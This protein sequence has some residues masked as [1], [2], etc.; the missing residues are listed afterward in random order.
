MPRFKLKGMLERDALADLWKHTLSQIPNTYGRLAYLASL[1]DPNSGSY[2]HYG[3]SAAFGREDSLGALRKSHEDTFLEWLRL[4]LSAKAEDL[5]EHFQ[6]LEEN[7]R[8]VV[9]YLARGMSY[10]GQAPD[11]A[12]RAQR[13][14]FQHEMEILLELLRNDSAVDRSPSSARPA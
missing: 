3:L 4:P 1:R 12:S 7:P 6:N 10:L 13:R 2:R 11:A 8:A 9:T 14:Q 5:R